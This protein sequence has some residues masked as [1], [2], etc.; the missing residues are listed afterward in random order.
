MISPLS[1]PKGEF[2]S[3]FRLYFL[4]FK[5]TFFFAPS[6][7]RVFVPSCQK[8][9]VQ[10]VQCVQ[11][12]E[13]FFVFGFLNLLSF[14]NFRMLTLPSPFG[15]RA[16]DGGFP[17]HPTFITTIFYLIP[18]FLPFFSPSKWS[19]ANHTNFLG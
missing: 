6:C 8:N 18:N 13:A 9:R 17:T 2:G 12:L 15:G 14:L 10:K 1:P 7:L 16:G 4:V 5:I 11:G 3:I 19:A